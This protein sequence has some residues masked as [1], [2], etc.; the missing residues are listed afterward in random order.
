MD[1]YT[2]TLMPEGTAVG[3]PAGTTLLEILEDRGYVTPTPCGG[4]GVCGKCLVGA[5]GSLSPKDAAETA[6]APDP[7]VRLACTAKI[8][9]DVVL[10]PEKNRAGCM[11]TRH[12]LDTTIRI[13]RRG[14][15]RH[16][17]DPG[18]AR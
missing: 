3:Y 1:K 8:A 4:R 10:H 13:Q 11:I 6:L 5:Q 9:G 16:D 12:E 17:L 15:Y 2:I 7:S 18:L 14:R